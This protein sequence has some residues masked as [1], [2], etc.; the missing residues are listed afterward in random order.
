MDRLRDAAPL[1]ARRGRPDLLHRP[2]TS[3]S[4][5]WGIKSKLTEL[6]VDTGAEAFFIGKAAALAEIYR[7]IETELRSQYFLRYLTNSTKGENE[8]RAIEVKLEN[9]KLKRQD[10]PRLF[11]LTTVG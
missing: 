9:P 5:T 7:K 8:F 1:R 6:A 3:P 4:S 2:R 10:D 11:P